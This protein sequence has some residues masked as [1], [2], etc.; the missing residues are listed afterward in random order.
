MATESWYGVAGST[1]MPT[2]R[3]GAAVGRLNGPVNRSRASTGHFAHASV[4]QAQSGPTMPD[5]A[6]ARAACAGYWSGS[7][8]FGLS[9]QSTPSTDSTPEYGS[10]AYAW[11]PP[12]AR[13]KSLEGGGG[14]VAGAGAPLVAAHRSSR[15]VA[16]M[17]RPLSPKS[18]IGTASYRSLTTVPT[19]TGLV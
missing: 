3:I 13:G 11:T 18:G 12:V 8:G 4:I 17:V 6:E 9:E 1:V 14:I 7:R 19:A 2:T 16:V 5:R 15:T 10:P